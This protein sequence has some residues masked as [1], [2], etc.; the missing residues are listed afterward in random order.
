MK[1]GVMKKNFRRRGYSLP[2]AIQR[3]NK[4][5]D[6]CRFRGARVPHLV[7][8]SATAL[9]PVVE[10]MPPLPAKKAWETKRDFAP[11]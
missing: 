7:N 2:Q 5:W 4:N 9:L 3:K 1:E 8:P 10:V 6:F 11:E